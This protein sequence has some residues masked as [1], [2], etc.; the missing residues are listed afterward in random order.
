MVLW[1][2]YE[3]SFHLL[4]A[5]LSLGFVAAIVMGLLH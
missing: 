2:H 5:G 3:P 4:T 1:R